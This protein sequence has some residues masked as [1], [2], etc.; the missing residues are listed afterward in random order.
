MAKIS[1]LRWGFTILALLVFL[2]L[3]VSV[4][5]QQA[6]L[7][8]LDQGLVKFIRQPVPRLIQSLII[9]ITTLGNPL[10]VLIITGGVV[11]RLVFT[12]RQRAAEFVLLNVL[13]W[14]GIGNF[15]IKSL[16]RRPRPIIDRL[17]TASSYSF[18]SG[19]SITVMLLFG[20]LIVLIANGLIANRTWQR[21][22]I[23]LASL[24][25]VAVG[26]SRVFVGVHYPSD[27][28]AGWLLG[29]GLLTL[30]QWFFTRNGR[31]LL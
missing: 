30:T 12:Q 11:L 20:S 21:L 14:A 1:R 18:P 28:L 6:G 13:G 9:G 15:V 8:Q 19:H 3:L 29:Y 25:I 27:V 31:S 22:T 17:V 16:V 23:G 7:V 26:V 4:S 5:T 24:W 2:G 10:A